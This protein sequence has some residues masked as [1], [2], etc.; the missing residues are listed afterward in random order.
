M[1][2]RIAIITLKGLGNFLNWKDKIEG[3]D[4]K[5]FPVTQT[6][7]IYAAVDWAD[8]VWLEWMNQSAVQATNH[9]NISQKDVILRVHSY[10]VLADFARNINW[11]YVN[12]IVYVADHIKN[13]LHRQVPDVP[14]RE[15]VIPNG[16]DLSQIEYT[17]HKPGYNIGFLGDISHKKAPLLILQL[18]N[19][20][21]QKDNKHTLQIAGQLQDRRYQLYLEHMIAEMGLKNSVTLHG[22]INDINSFFKKINY[23]ILT[24]P[25]ESQNMSVMEAMAAGVKPLIHNFYGARNVYTPDLL[26]NEISMAAKTILHDQEKYYSSERY[27]EFVKNAYSLDRTAKNIQKVINKLSR[28]GDLKDRGPH[29]DLAFQREQVN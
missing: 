11:K 4:I 21:Y 2:K 29:D 9:R 1:Q 23:I 8:I 12:D 18:F 28:E 6:Q 27:R 26:W 15:H 10:E 13:E 22:R 14:C 3:Y 20:I 25:W 19:E 7:E 17:E 5:V 24:S 16:V